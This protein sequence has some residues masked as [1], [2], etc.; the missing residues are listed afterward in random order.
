MAKPKKTPS[1]PE[2][3]N[4]WHLRILLHAYETPF[5]KLPRK[6]MESDQD[7]QARRELMVCG[8]IEPHDVEKN[9]ETGVSMSMN[10][11]TTYFEFDEHRY[12]RTTPEAALAI[13]QMLEKIGC[14]ADKAM[15]RFRE[16][17]GTGW[18]GV[19]AGIAAHLKVQKSNGQAQP[20]PVPPGLQG[21]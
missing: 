19:E 15:K 21:R 17:G 13:V 16:L 10:I 5:M 4:T 3:F 14:E 12:Y 20:L 2:R 11:N 6:L 9:E 18:S 8:L 1:L 7:R